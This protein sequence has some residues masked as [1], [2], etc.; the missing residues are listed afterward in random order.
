ML[1]NPFRVLHDD[2]WRAPASE[3]RSVRNSI[4]SSEVNDPVGVEAHG[5]AFHDAGLATEKAIEEVVLA[6]CDL[7]LADL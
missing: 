3:F 5:I 1:S 7:G 6:R 4:A 2:A